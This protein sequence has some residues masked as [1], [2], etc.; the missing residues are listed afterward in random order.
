MF[1]KLAARQVGHGL[2]A[3]HRTGASGNADESPLKVCRLRFN[4]VREQMVIGNPL[5]KRV[6]H[7]WVNFTGIG[8]EEAD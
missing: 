1:G 4:V 3:L 7:L 8:G 6:S 5:P 2:I